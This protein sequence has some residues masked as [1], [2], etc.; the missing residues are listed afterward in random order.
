MTTPIIAITAG[1]T[2]QRRE[3]L[4]SRLKDLTRA[5][6]LREALHIEHL[7][8]PVDQ[9]QSSTQREVALQRLDQQSRLIQEIRSAL[10]RIDSGAYGLCEKCEE[11]IP[12]KRL[13]AVPWAR[14]CV[15]CQSEIEARSPVQAPEFLEAA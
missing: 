11:S 14:L 5:A 3:A 9:I 2:K 6:G 4:E 8:D 7:A 15:R 12:R 13:D 1:E 10:E